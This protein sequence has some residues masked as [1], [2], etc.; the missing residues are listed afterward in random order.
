V[1]RPTDKKTLLFVSPQEKE[2][3]EDKLV[4]FVAF[5]CV[6]FEERVVCD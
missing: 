6:F 3:K 1:R 2:I 4:F 5:R